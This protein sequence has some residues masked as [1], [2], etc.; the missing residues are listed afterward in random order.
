M[1]PNVNKPTDVKVKEADINR[2]LQVYGIFSAFK[3]GKVPSV[4]YTCKS[5]PRGQVWNA[6]CLFQNDQIDVALNSFLATKGLTNPP[7]DLSADGKRLVADTREV[8]EQA[9]Q[10]LLSK[11]EGNLIQDF[12]WQTTQFD[13]NGVQG[14]TPPVN[15]DQAQRDG[16]EALQ[17]LRTLGTLLI[18]NGQFRKLRM[19]ELYPCLSMFI[20]CI[21]V[22][23]RSEVCALTHS[24]Q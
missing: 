22:W 6:N 11:N 8:I 10:L 18:T 17:G 23:R 21:H 12:I 16:D 15:K 1:T 7:S 4:R 20:T 2:K 13:P 19:F 3:Q 5:C 24:S 9:K 14:P